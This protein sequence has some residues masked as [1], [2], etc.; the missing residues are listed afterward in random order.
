MNFALVSFNLAKC[1]IKFQKILF[2]VGAHFNLKKIEW[3]DRKNDKK[4]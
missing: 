4:F 2:L 3:F 1:Q